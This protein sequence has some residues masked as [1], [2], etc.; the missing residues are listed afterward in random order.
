[1][2]SVFLL[3]P[4]CPHSLAQMLFTHAITVNTNPKCLHEN[5]DRC[6]NICQPA[7]LLAK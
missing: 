5:T 3:Q 7:N 6:L 4:S 2:Q 1:M